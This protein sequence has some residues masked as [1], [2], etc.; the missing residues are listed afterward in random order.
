MIFNSK[1]IEKQVEDFLENSF[2]A[3]DSLD[4][5]KVKKKDLCYFR[6]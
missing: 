3:E 5:N 1:S 6:D 2:K 4:N